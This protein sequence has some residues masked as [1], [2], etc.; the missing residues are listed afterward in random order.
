MLSNIDDPLEVINNKG[1]LAAKK[2]VKDEIKNVVEESNAQDFGLA[3]MW[4]IES[5]LKISRIIAHQ[6]FT[7]LKKTSIVFNKNIG[8]GYIKGPLAGYLSNLIDEK[9]RHESDQSDGYVKNKKCVM[10]TQSDA[11]FYLIEDNIEKYF[12]KMLK[13]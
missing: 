6:M 11:T 3:T 4:V 8:F 7:N 10:S 12:R 5:D 9:I 1:G 13:K 2:M